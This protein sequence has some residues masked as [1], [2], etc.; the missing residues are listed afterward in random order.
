MKTT[1]VI[2]LFALAVS[3]GLAWGAL[4]DD[5]PKD[6][7]SQL[8]NLTD[9]Q[10]VQKASAA[11][12]GEVNLG[13]LAARQASSP[14]VKKFA[15]RMV[16]D[17]TKANQELNQIA[18]KKRIRPAPAMDEKHRNLATQLGKLTGADFDR[19]YLK[20]QVKDHEEAVALF[21]AEAKNGKDPDLKA[22]ASKALPT[23][24]EHLE[25]VRKLAGGNRGGAGR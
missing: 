20:D 10:F 13:M 5:P 23:L 22:F 14:D 16:D 4:A 25:M 9:E 19:T 12:L 15:Q 7:A 3:L 17:H 6:K 8:S 24:K 11:G 1:L 2:S 18:D 21:E